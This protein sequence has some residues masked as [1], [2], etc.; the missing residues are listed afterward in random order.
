MEEAVVQF[1]WGLVSLVRDLTIS[2]ELLKSRPASFG[3]GANQTGGRAGC[4]YCR[5]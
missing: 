1:W 5:P 2:G 4:R 3:Q